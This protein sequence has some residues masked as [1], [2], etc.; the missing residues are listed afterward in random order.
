MPYST[1]PQSLTCWCAGIQRCCEAFHR[2]LC[3]TAEANVC[4]MCSAKKRQG[5]CRHQGQPGLYRTLHFSVCFSRADLG[6]G[7]VVKERFSNRKTF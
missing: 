1:P 2:Q 5:H 6:L 4:G 7:G 3:I